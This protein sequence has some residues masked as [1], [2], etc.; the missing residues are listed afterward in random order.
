[1]SPGRILYARSTPCTGPC[2]RSQFTKAEWTAPGS[3]LSGS[4]VVPELTSQYVTLEACHQATPSAMHRS[5]SPHGSLTLLVHWGRERERA[6][7]VEKQRSRSEPR[8]T[9]GCGSKRE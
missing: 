8:R 4:S 6:Q 5:S 2:S 9:V 3:E 1:M 7:F